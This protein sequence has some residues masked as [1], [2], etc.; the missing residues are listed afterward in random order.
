MAYELEPAD[1]RQ[2]RFVSNSDGTRRA[3]MVAA[4]G[5]I[6]ERVPELPT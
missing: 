2:I 4:R 1:G 3:Y 6:P 5:G